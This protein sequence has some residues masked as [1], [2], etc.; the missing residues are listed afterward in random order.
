MSADEPVDPRTPSMKDVFEYVYWKEFWGK[1]SGEGSTIANT[2]PYVDFL[3]R[4]LKRMDIKSV[5]D[6]GCG[7]WQFSETI[8]WGDIRYR[9][10]DVAVKLVAA[11]QQRHGRPNISFHTIEDDFSVLPEADLLIVKDVMQ[12]WPHKAI[13]RFRPMLER[14]RHVLITNCVAP[15]GKTDN[16][17]ILLG[18]FR[19]LDLRRPP[20]AWPLTEVCRYAVPRPWWRRLKPPAWRKSVLL[21]RRPDAP[22]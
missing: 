6:L 3:H 15:R 13:H 9:G 17:D 4:F 11:N 1:G 16:V 2:R 19:P 21:Y 8:A 18:E 14:Y 20:F 5:V 10:Y 22:S 7:D 12:H